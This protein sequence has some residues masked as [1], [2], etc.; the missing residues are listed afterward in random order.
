MPTRRA[1]IAGLALLPLAGPALAHSYK[2]GTVR[3]GHPWTQPTR[4]PVT[5]VFIALLNT[6]DVVDRLVG[7]TT[8]IAEGVR[9]VDLVDGLPAVVDALD[10]L[11][12]RPVPMRPGA[13]S[14]RLLGVRQ[15]LVLG[16]RFT[17][18]LAFE[19]AGTVEVEIYVELEP[20]H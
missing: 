8:P 20:G 16:E 5:D 9:I 12:M 13:R 4:D 15:P 2:A 3:I 1:L 7:A 14:L 19:R 10:L 17:M 18:T 11:P 6:G